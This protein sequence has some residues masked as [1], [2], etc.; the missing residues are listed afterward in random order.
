MRKHRKQGQTSYL[1]SSEGLLSW[2][3]SPWPRHQGTSCFGTTGNPTRRQPTW[4]LHSSEQSRSHQY[5]LR[6]R[7]WHVFGLQHATTWA[8]SGTP[9]CGSSSSNMSSSSPTVISV[10]WECPSVPIFNPGPSRVAVG[11]K[12]RGE[13]MQI[14]GRP[15]DVFFRGWLNM[16]APSSSLAAH[17]TSIAPIWLQ[18]STCLEMVGEMKSN[19]ARF[20]R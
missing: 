5:C 20:H 3:R 11:W 8:E 7:P 4:V 17:Q 2:M 1:P 14:S 15:S 16:V 9:T 6:C 10:N 19:T 18:Q 13:S 12:C